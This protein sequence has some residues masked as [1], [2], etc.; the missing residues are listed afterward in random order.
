[1]DETMADEKTG[2]DVS[3]TSPMS[4]PTGAPGQPDAP[5]LAPKH[6]PVSN[7][8]PH[9]A[10]VPT[11]PLKV[12][13]GPPVTTVM[14]P[15]PEMEIEI[16]V[17]APPDYSKDLSMPAAPEPVAT[18]HERTL[19]NNAVIPPQDAIEA[20]VGLVKQ[21]PRAAAVPDPNRPD[22]AKILE[23][24]K[25]PEKRD[26][27][28]AGEKKRS[29][30]V[31]PVKDLDAVLSA[32]ITENPVQESAPRSAGTQPDA[33]IHVPQ[34]EVFHE[35]MSIVPVHT[36]KQDLQQVVRDQKISVVRAVALEQEKKRSARIETPPEPTSKAP[37][38]II[39][40][41]FLLLLGVGAIAGVY[42]IATLQSAPAAQ[43]KD[44]ALVFAEQTLDFP[45]PNDAPQSIKSTL[46]KGREVGGAL[47]AMMH[48]V[49][50]VT[51]SSADGS[52][53]TRNATLAEFFK[54]IGANPP[55]AL[56][57]A[58][59]DDFFFGFHTVD[60]NAPIIV[61]QVTAYDRAFDGM[62]NW[63][64]TINGD[65]SPIFTAVPRLMIGQDGLQIQRP[66][67][68]LV[69]RNYDVRA[70]KDDSGAIQLYYSF[71]TRDLL[72]IAESPY[73]FTEILSR[74]Q[75]GRRL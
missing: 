51:T 59:G 48:V 22:M 64:K 13:P 42:Y 71:P 56:M 23:G 17:P 73:T 54:A 10:V 60:K 49:P 45:I 68:D 5:V 16:T 19:P 61:I 43:I 27:T 3:K 65:L 55:D 2:S 37:A 57:R 74:L 41:V 21:P 70:L 14:P 9:Q 39:S 69:M 24:I 18:T 72:I 30:P 11:E 36:L 63:E 33:G 75:A 35:D 46:A 34:Q 32:R 7:I 8:M 26:Y 66:F 20:E 1:M 29:S 47:G 12:P 53:S 38:I 44:D 62:L 50:K 58:L 52:V 67:S 4:Q 25:L 28:P 6:P 31:T 15:R 40:I